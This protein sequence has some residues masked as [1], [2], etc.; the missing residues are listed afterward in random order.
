[1]KQRVSNASQ[2]LDKPLDFEHMIKIA[3]IKLYSVYVV[4]KQGN[5][6]SETTEFY[7]TNTMKQGV[8]K[9]VSPMTILEWKKGN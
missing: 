6:F 5:L 1:M 8:S 2:T 4:I 7:R 3:T 9:T